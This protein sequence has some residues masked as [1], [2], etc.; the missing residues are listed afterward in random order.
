MLTLRRRVLLGAAASSALATPTFSQVADEL[1]IGAPL[2]LTGPLA[3]EGRKQRRG[4]DL[5][6]KGPSGIIRIG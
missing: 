6:A 4:Y 5:W 2:P 3:P 1:R